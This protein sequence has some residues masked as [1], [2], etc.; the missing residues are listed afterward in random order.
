MKSGREPFHTAS[1]HAGFALIDYWRWAESDL[2]NN[3]RRA[4][5]AEYLVAR[6]VGAV[7]KPRVEWASFDVATPKGV[8]IEVK[9]SAYAQSWAQRGPS[10]ITF[11]IA[12]RKSSWDPATNTEVRHDPPRR[13]A[14]VYV[15][16]VLGDESGCEPD[17]LDL[18]DWRFYVA[19]TSLLD[20]EV[21]SQRMI[22]LR[23]LA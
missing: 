16:C 21:P 3:T 22:G 11:D 13:V 15:F 8:R 12:P 19:A 9:S 10:V 4:T 14:D 6:A 2:L 23:P 20:R 1:V 17:P 18:A 7:D 5:V